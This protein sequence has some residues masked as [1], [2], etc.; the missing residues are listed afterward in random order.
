MSFT[1]KEMSSLK[2]VIKTC[3]MPDYGLFHL[4]SY[5]GGEGTP[6]IHQKNTRHYTCKGHTNKF[7]LAISE[8][9][10]IG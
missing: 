10:K 8:T 5:R 9:P 6:K 2:P 3:F 1:E 4:N 7:I